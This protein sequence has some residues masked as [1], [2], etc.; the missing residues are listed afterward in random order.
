MK[1]ANQAIPRHFRRGFPL[2]KYLKNKQIAAR[3][4]GV[5]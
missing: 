5:S 1:L 3:V 4:P 2:K